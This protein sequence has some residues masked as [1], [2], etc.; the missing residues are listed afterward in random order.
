MDALWV[1]L[2]PR[3]FFFL[4]SIMTIIIV[5]DGNS[6]VSF[7]FFLMLILFKVYN[8]KKN[9]AYVL[10]NDEPPAADSGNSSSTSDKSSETNTANFGINSADD[11]QSINSAGG[12]T[13]GVISL[14]ARDGF[15]LVHSVPKF[16]SLASS[17]FTWA[18]ASKIY[19]QS[20]LCISMTPTEINMASRQV[21]LHPNHN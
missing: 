11:D 16:P 13:K 2:W 7:S 20:F 17:T 15:W 12:H 9:V 1:E 21:F 3:Y 14:D 10:Y 6:L 8:G 19:G 5:L 4:P 18:N